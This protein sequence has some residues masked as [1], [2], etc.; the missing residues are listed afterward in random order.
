MPASFFSGLAIIISVVFV[1]VVSAVGV[2]SPVKAS[3]VHKHRHRFARHRRKFS[4]GTEHSPSNVG[5][6]DVARLT[7]YELAAA[8]RLHASRGGVAEN[9]ALS[10]I[11]AD[12][13]RRVRVPKK[14]KKVWI[15][16][17]SRSGSSTMEQLVDLA[18][19][20]SGQNI[21]SLKRSV[22][23]LFEPCHEGD[24]YRGK[25]ITKNDLSMCP[26]F[27]HDVKE[28]NFGAIQKLFYWDHPRAR[29]TNV[30]YSGLQAE[31]DCK[32]AAVRVFK[33]I[34]MN[35][36]AHQI[37]PVLKADPSL[38]IVHLIRDPRAIFASR[39]HTPTYKH[40]ND[41]DI[42]EVCKQMQSNAPIKHPRLLTVKF[43][44]WVQNPVKWSKEVYRFLGLRFGER[45][46]MW[47]RGNFN[48]PPDVFRHSL[49]AGP[50]GSCRLNSTAVAFKWKEQLNQTQLDL[51]K[52]DAC[53]E[54]LK[55][56]G[57]QANLG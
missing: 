20:A 6:E 14:V 34:T 33:T 51:F 22:F 40:V 19:P 3:L 16:S 18:L 4:K 32:R 7:A 44:D 55:L 12:Q 42:V 37:L 24:I 2:K 25:K 31:I 17:F 9:V 50:F 48:P 45:Q 36:M 26:N 5:Q 28:C 53:Q 49:E 57:Y 52:A 39:L 47:I 13:L 54:A 43:E 23:A 41:T 46:E 35:D 29:H 11:A 27:L 10:Y 8:H 38:H 15:T 56:Y 21:L 1:D 30:E